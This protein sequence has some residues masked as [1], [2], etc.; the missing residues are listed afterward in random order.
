M[1][2]LKGTGEGRVNCMTQDDIRADWSVL[3][4]KLEEVSG[5]D[6]EIK[7]KGEVKVDCLP[8]GVHDFKATVQPGRA[9]G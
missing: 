2:N 6:I 4:T 1:P 5:N 9:S 8:A 7:M 3:R